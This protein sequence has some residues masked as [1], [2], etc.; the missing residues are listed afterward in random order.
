[1]NDDELKSLLNTW[2]APLTPAS[3]RRKVLPVRKLSWRR[4]LTGE[5]RLLLPAAAVGLCLIIVPGYWW[6]RPPA[7]HT[8]SDFE[9]VTQFQPRIVRTT[10]ETR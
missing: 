1:M 5:L 7:E 10:Y 4:L 2:S 8:L 3:L 9:H 6:R